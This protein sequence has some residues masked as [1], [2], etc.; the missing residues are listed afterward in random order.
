MKTK[1]AIIG[2]GLSG[3][4]CA[5]QLEKKGHDYILI[6]GSSRLG[7]RVGSV[8]EK[9]Y[10]F[11]VGFQV[12]NTAYSIT[13]SQ[14]DLK[15]LDLQ[16]FKPG[17]I[18]HDGK[19]FQMITDPLRD[20]GK[21]FVSLFSSISNFS[22]KLRVLSLKIDLANYSIDSDKTEDVSTFEYLES[23]GFSKQFIELFFRPFFAGVFLEKKLET[24]SKFFKYVFSNFSRGLAAI[25][26]DGMQKIPDQFQNNINMNSVILNSYVKSIKS[27]NK[28]ILD[29]EDE[30]IADSIVITASSHEL[31]GDKPVYFNPVVNLYFSSQIIPENGQYIYLFPKD[32]LI[33]NI[34]ILSS[35]SP[36]Y[37]SSPSNCLMSVS[38]LA[39]MFDKTLIENVKKKLANYFGG[40]KNSYDCL[41][42]F[43]I[44]KATIKQYNN[45]FSGNSV[46]IYDNI[47]VTG[48]HKVNGSIEGA[49][50]SGI[51]ASD[52][53][54][55]ASYS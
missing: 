2:G 54:I 53:I 25:P 49:V 22:D 27:N 21:I 52:H 38:I 1:T 24:S 10:I 51:Q 46:N 35:V 8:Y 47:V 9:G 23:R 32:D 36:N 6:E 41:R 28:I 43:L 42:S 48:Q 26:L 7:G 40:N 4:S 29:N 11:D 55:K 5:I 13:N 39:D 50:I 44:K 37:S 15:A 12:Y 33:N 45:F 17:A 19:T 20:I 18:I 14:L 16:L 30:I 34:A 3:L 31:T